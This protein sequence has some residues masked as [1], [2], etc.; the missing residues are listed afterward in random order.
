MPCELSTVQYPEQYSYPKQA[1]DNQPDHQGQATRTPEAALA[2]LSL[3]L[4]GA[5][6]AGESGG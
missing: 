4:P 3:E 1:A 2:W 5:F 6:T